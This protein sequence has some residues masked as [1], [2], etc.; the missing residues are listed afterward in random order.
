MPFFNTFA[1]AN[2]QSPSLP[3]EKGW[4][5]ITIQDCMSR[6]GIAAI[7]RNTGSKGDANQARKPSAR[8]SLSF[9]S[10]PAVRRFW[11]YDPA[12]AE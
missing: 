12:R 1:P 4:A 6:S 10:T 5:R 2:S 11:S 8:Q 3:T 9:W 7:Q